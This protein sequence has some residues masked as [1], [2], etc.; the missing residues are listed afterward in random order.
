MSKKRH[1]AEAIIT[2]LRE[3]EVLQTKG[4]SLAEAIR[5]LGISDAT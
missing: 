1:T 3:V 5:Q 2:M 4:Q